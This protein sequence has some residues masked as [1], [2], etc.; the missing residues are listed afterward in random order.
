MLWIV[1]LR[2]LHIYLPVQVSSGTVD[3]AKKLIDKILRQCNK[4]LMDDEQVSLPANVYC[5][6][7]NL[8]LCEKIYFIVNVVLTVYNVL[9]FVSI[10]D[11]KILCCKFSSKLWTN[12]VHVTEV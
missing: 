8:K 5:K 10:K 6:V 9:L 1:V 4:P 3:Q 11:I 7:R 2:F 12:A